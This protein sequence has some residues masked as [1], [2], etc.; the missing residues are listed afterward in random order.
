VTPIFVAHDGTAVR[1]TC[2]LTGLHPIFLAP[3]LVMWVDDLS[4]DPINAVATDMATK[5]PDVPNETIR[6]SVIYTGPTWRVLSNDWSTFVFT[7]PGV[8][9]V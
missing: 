3:D 2:D 5:S 8:R 9:R 6:G 4:L 7:Y 1:R